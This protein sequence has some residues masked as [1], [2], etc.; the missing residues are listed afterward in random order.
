MQ[1]SPVGFAFDTVEEVPK[2]AKKI[3]ETSQ[4]QPERIK[5]AQAAF[6]AFL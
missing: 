2:E 1:G 6:P 3:T 5:R 4:N